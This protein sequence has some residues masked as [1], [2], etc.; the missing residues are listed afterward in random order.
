MSTTAK[1]RKAT[2]AKRAAT[3]KNAA[4]AQKTEQQPAEQPA[5]QPAT[6][7]ISDQ[8]AQDATPPRKP[9]GAPALWPFQQ[10]PRRQRAQFLRALKK[11]EDTSHSVQSDAD[12]DEDESSQLE[13][14]AASYEMLADL[15][16]TLRLAARDAD[17][18]DE[19]ANAA[20]D[21]DLTALSNWYMDRFQV[22]EA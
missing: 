15:Q 4:A 22:G 18:F 5:E 19:W 21:A 16:D 7:P 11:V 12:E 20:A 10:L 6:E 2:T 14:A 17:A 9:K 13:R 3:V 1:S 8:M